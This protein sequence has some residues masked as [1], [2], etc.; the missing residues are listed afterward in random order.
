MLSK[1]GWPDE[2]P[3]WNW[4]GYE[5]EVLSVCAYSCCDSVRLYLNGKWLATKSVSDKLKADF[6]VPYSAGC[7][8]AVGIKDGREVV[9]KSLQTTSRTHHIILLPEKMTVS[10]DPNDLV[11]VEIRIVDE[12]GRLIPD[13]PV[14]L[15]MIVE[16]DGILLASGNAAPDDM[17]SFRNSSCTTYQGKC[18]VILQPGRKSGIIRLKVLAEGMPSVETMINIASVRHTLF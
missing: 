5:S 7:L 4:K 1:W 6:E 12:A 10:A 16:G 17:K 8:L 9:R 3:H 14:R 11:F 2:Y 15:K 18:Q 13:I